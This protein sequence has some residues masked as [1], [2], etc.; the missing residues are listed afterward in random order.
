MSEPAVSVIV[1]AYNEA[2]NLEPVVREIADALG[3][4]GCSH[5]IVV[6]DDGSTDGTGAAADAL[7][8]QLAAV[9]VVHHPANRGLGGVYRTGF[10]EARGQ[11][12]TFFPADGQFPATNLEAFVPRM[13][14]LDLLL[15]YIEESAGTWWAD[16][17]AGGERLLYRLLFGRMP[18]F[19][20]VF[21]LRREM[22][23]RFTLRSEGRGWSIVLE[24]ILRVTRAG[25]RVRSVPNTLRPRR[26]GHSKVRNLRTITSNL[27]Q[28]L[29]LRRL[30]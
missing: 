30:L 6:V 14:E 28:V 24:M 7:A 19:Q 20:G 22:L 3:R 21:V 1:M 10:T 5:E 15:G 17:L 13:A 23:D 26:S 9:R 18:R 2:Q 16:L 27:G 25:G 11:L 8:A 29:A 12:L 4:L